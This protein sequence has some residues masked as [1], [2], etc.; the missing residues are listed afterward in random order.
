VLVD[1]IVDPEGGQPVVVA[2]AS[3]QQ[4][5]LSIRR[6]SWAS[7]PATKLH[8]GVLMPCAHTLLPGLVP[9][10]GVHARNSAIYFGSSGPTHGPCCFEGSRSRFR[11]WGIAVHV[12][13]MCCVSDERGGS[14]KK[15]SQSCLRLTRLEKG[16]RTW[17]PEINQ[18]LYDRAHL[19]FGMV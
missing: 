1:L 8:R 13:S 15:T 3:P 18:K 17:E 11:A 7:T 6:F 19:Q 16:C 10:D 5:S 12:R 14:N 4:G 2:C 9:Q